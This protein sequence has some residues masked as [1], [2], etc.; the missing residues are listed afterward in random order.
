MQP[1]RPLPPCPAQSLQRT[2]AILSLDMPSVNREAYQ[3]Q[4]E[5]ARERLIR[6]IGAQADHCAQAVLRRKVLEALGI[7]LRAA[8]EIVVDKVQ[9]RHTSDRDRLRPSRRRGARRGLG[10]LRHRIKHGER[11]KKSP[12]TKVRRVGMR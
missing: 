12:I 2:D 6:V 4:I 1:Y 5:P 10:L 3:P 9:V 8:K 7:G 11:E